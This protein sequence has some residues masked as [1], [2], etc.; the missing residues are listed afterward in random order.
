MVVALSY[1]SPQLQLLQPQQQPQQQQLQQQQQQPL[2]IALPAGHAI[3]RLPS[4]IRRIPGTRSLEVISSLPRAERPP[5]PQPQPQ[6]PSIRPDLLAQPL[7]GSLAILG[8]KLVTS[9]PASTTAITTTTISKPIPTEPVLKPVEGS[10]ATASLIASTTSSSSKSRSLIKALSDD[11]EAERRADFHRKEVL[12]LVS[13]R[14]VQ[15][16]VLWLLVADFVADGCR[17]C[18]QTASILEHTEPSRRSRKS[19]IIRPPL[20]SDHLERYCTRPSRLDEAE[21]GLLR[22]AKELE[23]ALSTTT[24]PYTCCRECFFPQSVC[25][26]FE[27]KEDNS[28]A[29]ERKA[30][31]QCGRKGQLVDFLFLRLSKGQEAVVFEEARDLLDIM[32]KL[33][34]LVG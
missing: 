28:G 30:G 3:R 19:S 23:K 5:R 15:V 8:N 14:Q 24:D 11:N 26:A 1:R 31:V 7:L 29:Y 16:K 25:E 33:G 21:K 32:G 4:N 6:A 18:K 10:I 9:L 34:K 12:L 13:R 2:L 27:E 22:Q 20:D 17:L